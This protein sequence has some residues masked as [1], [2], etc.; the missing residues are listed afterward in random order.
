MITAIKLV[1]S[2]AWDFIRPFVL[3]LLSQGGQ[4]LAQVAMDTVTT[5]AANYASAPGEQKRQISFDLIRAQLQQ[6]GVQ[7]GASVINAAIEAAVQRLK[8]AR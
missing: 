8:T 6:Q 7:L 4:I 2:S 1:M 5:V 3:M